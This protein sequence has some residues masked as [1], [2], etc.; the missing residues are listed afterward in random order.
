MHIRTHRTLNSL[1]TRTACTALDEPKQT[2][3]SESGTRRQRGR[4]G[5]ERRGERG[6]RK[7]RADETESQRGPTNPPP[8]AL[9]PW[10]VIAYAHRRTC[11]RAHIIVARSSLHFGLTS[12]CKYTRGTKARITSSWSRFV[13]CVMSSI[14]ARSNSND[15]CV[16]WRTLWK[17]CQRQFARP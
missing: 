16:R 8:H 10:K 7:A 14:V 3:A 1:N 2:S 11:A 12:N 13:R 15:V 6:E 9:T 4:A 5:R 17:P